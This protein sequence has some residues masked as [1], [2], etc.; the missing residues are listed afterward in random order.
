M[1]NTETSMREMRHIV[2]LFSKSSDFDEQW[3]LFK[4]YLNTAHSLSD[5]DSVAKVNFQ[6]NELMNFALVLRNI[7]HHQPAKWHFGKHDVQPTSMSFNFSQNAG[8]NFSAELSLVIQKNTLEGQELQKILGDNSK[9]QLAVLRAS[10]EK[11]NRHVIIVLSLMQQVQE[12]V[13]QYCKNQGQYTERYDNEPHG[14]T[15]IQNA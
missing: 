5:N 14:Y 8:V 10:L 6:Q 11:V 12:Y 2:T 4:A 7:L 1:T 13:E 9:K 3:I 15:L